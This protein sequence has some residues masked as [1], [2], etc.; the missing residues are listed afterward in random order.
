MK[1]FAIALVL[2]LIVTAGVF[3]QDSFTVDLSKLGELKNSEPINTPYGMFVINFPEGTFP[4]NLPWAQYNRIR[5]I[6][7]YFRANGA[8]VRQG[9]ENAFVVLVY[10]PNGDVAG[11]PQGPGP[12]TPV[13]IFNVG[14]SNNRSGAISSPA[15]AGIT[16]LTQAPGAILLQRQGP[17]SPVRFI[18]LV[19]L[20]F[21]KQ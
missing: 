2:C 15:G 8:E 13:K 6:F 17:D 1:K 3:A 11:P 10:D 9:N 7:K 18:E 14:G 19:E 16:P 5:V 4:A 12:N 20:T 21:F